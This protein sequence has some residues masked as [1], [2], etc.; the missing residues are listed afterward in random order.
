MYTNNAR[1]TAARSVNVMFIWG[2]AV[3][4]VILFF[5]EVF[6][7][8]FIGGRDTAMLL[9][10]FAFLGLILAG[11][12]GVIVL[13]AWNLRRLS[14][15]RLYNSLIEEDHDGILTYESI[16][17]MLGISEAKAL[18]EVMWMVRRHF[19]INLTAG[20]TAIRV[21]LIPDKSEFVKLTCSTCGATVSVRKGGGGRCDSCGTYMRDEVR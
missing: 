13:C 21:D 10:L 6:I 7:L 16:G 3:P 8:T 17:L 9:F 4:L 5:F 20:R 2:A 18:K 12:A 1:V 15:V 14:R 19:L 11:L